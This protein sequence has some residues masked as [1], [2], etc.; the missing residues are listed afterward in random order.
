MVQ[1]F[2]LLFG[3]FMIFKAFPVNGNIVFIVGD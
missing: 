1:N 3:L 2:F